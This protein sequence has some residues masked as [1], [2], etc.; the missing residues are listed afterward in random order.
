MADW[1][2][3]MADV[4]DYLKEGLKILNGDWEKLKEAYSRGSY[5]I[6]DSND[7][8]KISKNIKRRFKRSYRSFLGPFLGHGNFSNL[9]GQ[10][11]ST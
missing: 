10:L 3:E 5:R 4:W 7:S 11:D 1:E 8:I 6:W 9:R 2:D